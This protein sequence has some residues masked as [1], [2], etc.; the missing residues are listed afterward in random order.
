MKTISQEEIEALIREGHPSIG[1]LIAA[2]EE[3][4]QLYGRGQAENTHKKVASSTNPYHVHIELGARIPGYE[5]LKV[6]DERKPGGKTEKDITI[7]LTHGDETFTIKGDYITDARTGIAGALAA[8]YLTDKIDTIAIIGAGKV[9]RQFALAAEYLFHPEEIRFA[10]RSE[11]SRR[12]FEEFLRKYTHASIK[13]YDIYNAGQRIELLSGA[14]MLFEAAP[15]DTQLRYEEIALMQ[16]NAHISSMT[17]D[18][19]Q[20]NFEEEVLRRCKII[21]DDESAARKSGELRHVPDANVLGTIGEAALGKLHAYKKE[22]T[23]YDS[24]GMG[25]SDL[26]IAKLIVAKFQR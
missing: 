19:L 1:E 23:F 7:T 18:G 10:T 8:K 17:G 16:P 21:V 14:D 20:H 22:R 4:F 11:T 6:I 13:A 12:E 25:I 26:G 3:V 24:T 15:L 2:L 9:P 5:L